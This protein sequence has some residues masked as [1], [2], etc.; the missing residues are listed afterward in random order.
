M[1]AL[2]HEIEARIRGPGAPSR[3]APDKK[4]NEGLPAA[5]DR[6][7]SSTRV[8]DAAR[9]DLRRHGPQAAAP[10]RPA[11]QLWA[12]AAPRCCAPA[13]TGPG[14]RPPEPRQAACGAAPLALTETQARATS[15]LLAHAS[16]RPAITAQAAPLR[17]AMACGASS[18]GPRHTTCSALRARFR[19]YSG[20]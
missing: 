10:Q 16:A 6:R 17:L 8:P 13:N 20:S 2:A 12:Q 5:R 3:C 14:H 11:R 15:L 4:R 19:S 7:V 1:L 18:R 9:Q